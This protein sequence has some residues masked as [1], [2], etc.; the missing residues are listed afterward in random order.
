V[1]A[2]PI[3][4]LALPA[5]LAL[6]LAACAHLAPPPAPPLA[7]YVV[8][9][10]EGVAVAR[11]LTDAP[12]CPALQV[13]GRPQ[14]MALRAAP[15]TMPLRSTN[16]KPADSKPSA[17][18]VLACEATLPAGAASASVAGQPLPLPKA[19]PQRIVVLGD[20]GCRLLKNSDS[21]QPCNDPAQYPFATVAAQAAAWHP[22]LVVHVGDYHYR[23]SPCPDGNA[24]CAGSPWGYGWDAWN[25]DFF[26]PGAAL[27]KAAPWVVARGNHEA[28]HRGGQGWWR[29]LDP[30]PLRPGQ[31]CN[32]DADDAL[33]NY[34]DP[35][36]VPLGPDS[37]LLVID[38][39]ATTWR[40]LKPGDLGYDKYRDTYRQLDAL[41]RR[42]PH[43][44]GVTHHPLLALGADHDK[45]GKV[46]ILKGDL[47]L[48]QSFGSLNPQLLPAAIQTML[49]GHVHLW[50]QM[51][52]SSGHP[53][54]FVSGFSGTAEDIVPLPLPVPAGVSPAEGAVVRNASAW[55]DG[56]GFMTMERRG[57]EQWEVGVHDLQGR[58]RNTCQI[59]GRQSACAVMQVR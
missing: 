36:A 40:G 59:D 51:S 9:G 30:R 50:Q 20:T 3:R 37:Q 38:T 16:S 41:A 10:P 6:L 48:Q 43:N 14:A 49:S 7:A 46:V 25:A 22:D 18:P 8:L 54:Q 21:Y 4:H 24:G 35:Y 23:E 55:I 1:P 58:L 17:F 34:S 53:S 27:L 15:A 19:A 13:D 57:P 45:D 2:V 12:A 33:G 56:F 44:I 5:S 52:F 32:A 47:G 31:D 39:A 29:F 11:V 26:T 42:A 28:C